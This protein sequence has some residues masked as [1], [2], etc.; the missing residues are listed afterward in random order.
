MSYFNH[1]FI[2]SFYNTATSA[3]TNNTLTQNISGGN[4]A[5]VQ[6]SDTNVWETINPA[7]GSATTLGWVTPPSTTAYGTS[8]GLDAK[9]LV[10]LVQ[11]SILPNDKIGSHGGFKET[12]KSKGINVKYITGLWKKSAAASTTS[13]IRVIVGPTCAPCGEPLRFRLDVKGSP[14]L[15][16]L[17]RNAYAI[18]DSEFS[19][20]NNAS[21]C[22]ANN[23]EY[24][25]PV[26]ALAKIGA[27]L[28]Q[29]P[30][31]GKFLST[32]LATTA[33]LHYANTSAGLGTIASPAGIAPHTINDVIG[34]SPTYTPETT[35]TR[36][37]ALTLEANTLANLS[38]NFGFGSF[39]TRDFYETEPITFAG[40]ILDETGNPCNNCGT[41]TTTIG[42]RPET[43]GETVVRDLLLT[44]SYM[45]NPINRGNKDSARMREILG[46]DASNSYSSISRTTNYDVNYIE[47]VVP[48]FNN[49]SSTF[50]SEQYL[51]KI[52]STTSATTVVDNMMT[53]LAA[54][55]GVSYVTSNT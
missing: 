15:R 50:D 46:F 34:T 8:D 33:T 41:V 37:A 39:D 19:L 14:A 11:G 30:I 54:A 55:S 42:V 47:H 51:Y 25:D 24:L 49:P 16:F 29:D 40:S 21:V 52:Y 5:L 17:N 31:I 53:A 2:K 45:Q 1:S 43:T 22:C 18:A 44:E 10:Y 3:V 32:T 26:V 13:K 36:W 23:Q 9:K 6:V 35:P 12:V 20:N 27:F 4:L 48:R 28:I 7:T 38:T